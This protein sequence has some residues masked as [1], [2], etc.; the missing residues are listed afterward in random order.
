[1]KQQ[2]NELTHELCVRAVLDTLEHKWTRGDFVNTISKYGGV[3][4][5]AI[6][7]ARYEQDMNLK[8]EAADSIACEVEQ[9]LLDVLD[10][11]ETDLDLDPVHIRKQ[12]DGI[13]L[14]KRNIASCCPMH[15]IFGHLLVLG[16]EPLFRAR[17][18]PHQ[19]ASIPGR[20]QTGIK[21]S[22]ERALHK[23][24]LAIRAAKKL[25]VHHAY[26]ST[27]GAIV[28][29]LTARDI[30]S[31]KW[32]LALLGQLLAMNPGYTLLIGGYPDAW[33]F[34]YVMSYLVRY[35][36]SRVKTRRGLRVRYVAAVKTY[37]DDVVLMGRRVADLESA[38]RACSGWLSDSF[39]LQFKPKTKDSRILSFVEEH[40]HR[41]Q[42]RPGAHGCG[43]IDIGG[44]KVHR[45]YTSI[46]WTIF[47]RI[48]R[49]FLRAAEYVQRTG[50][51]PLV[52]AY[53][54]VSYKG[55]FDNTDSRKARETY[56]V[57][58]LFRLARAVVSWV[59]R[60]STVGRRFK[61]CSILKS[62]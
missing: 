6:R 15:Q 52:R 58:E 32:I 2:Y 40:E 59:A 60:Q 31:A 7:Q 3:T 36:M 53:K 62:A 51:I 4:P 37:M 45:N 14:K 22:V 13:S 9:R 26:E 1:M 16:M 42:S 54:I 48:R 29:G 23:K 30:P 19:F 49:Q 44:Y 56:K 38:A 12:I 28:L 61:Q 25:D 20:G 5:E 18:T 46:R 41:K 35:A 55:Y 57:D 11:T 8:L 34:N 50:T 47:K 24:K 21:R 33:L 10:G 43:C 39:G 27:S 17:I